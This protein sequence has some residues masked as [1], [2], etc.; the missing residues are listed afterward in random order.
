[1]AQAVSRQPLIAETCLQSQ[2]GLCGICGGQSVTGTGFA[3][4]YFAFLL[5][6]S[7]RQCFILIYLSPTLY[8]LNSFH[9]RYITHLM[10]KRN[11]YC[12]HHRH[13]HHHHHQCIWNTGSCIEN[14]T[15]THGK[16]QLLT[17]PHI[18]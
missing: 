10:K 1:M 16:L 3:S 13:H 11:C 18:M 15:Q 7:F 5:S 4:E 6:V 8:N 2:T 17:F 9:R 12:Y 14:R